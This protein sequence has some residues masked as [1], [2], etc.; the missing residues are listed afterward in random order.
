MHRRERGP[1]AASGRPP[2]AT[3]G[4]VHRQ[5]PDD[6]ADQHHPLDAEVDDAG[7]LGHDLAERGEE[8]R[9]AR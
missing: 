8:E 5:E 2:G 1:A 3:P 7:P 6:G 9:G 4:L